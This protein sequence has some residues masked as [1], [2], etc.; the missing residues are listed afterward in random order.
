MSLSRVVCWSLLFALLSGCAS[1]K[2]FQDVRRSCAPS[3]VATW[4]QPAKMR[5]ARLYQCTITPSSAITLKEGVLQSGKQ[6]RGI[7]DKDKARWAVVPRYDSIYYFNDKVVYARLPGES[8]WRLLSPRAGQVDTVYGFSY[9]YY[10]PEGGRTSSIMA[11]TDEARTRAV[12][13]D[14]EGRNTREITDIDGEITNEDGFV[15]RNIHGGTA[16]RGVLVRHRRDGEHFYQV[17][18]SAAEPIGP[19]FPVAETWMSVMID[20]EYRS[21]ASPKYEERYVL[22]HQRDDGTIWPLIFGKDKLVLPSEHSRGFDGYLVEGGDRNKP[23]SLRVFYEKF[24]NGDET[25]WR[26]GIVPRS[27]HP[28]AFA[29]RK[30]GDLRGWRVIESPSIP[31]GGIAFIEQKD[32]GSYML[33]SNRELPFP[34]NLGAYYD[35]EANAERALAHAAESVAQ[36]ELAQKQAIQAYAEEARKQEAS[37]QQQSRDLFAVIDRAGPNPVNLSTYGYETEYY[38]AMGGRRCEEFRRQYRQWQDSHN[39]GVEAANRQ[40]LQQVYREQLDLDKVRQSTECFRQAAQSKSRAVSGQ[41]NWY[42]SSKG[43]KPD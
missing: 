2:A 41:Q 24:V 11:F 36:H 19:R 35:S 28:D 12:R 26:G 10:G 21:G 25:R 3:P 37:R 27:L 43:C 30:T 18:N 9:A 15:V 16:A 39:R 33:L 5:D 34:G 38:C 42:Y 1:Q 6:Y 13:F 32:N 4:F 22:V 29:T 7:W 23:P 14:R 20:A 8:V 40:R 31:L 17:Y